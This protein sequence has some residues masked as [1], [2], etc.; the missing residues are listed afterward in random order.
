[1]KPLADNK[2]RHTLYNRYA[3]KWSLTEEEIVL[4]K[5]EKGETGFI[6]IFFLSHIFIMV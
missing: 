3:N 1:M 4:S 2:E 5:N 6:Y